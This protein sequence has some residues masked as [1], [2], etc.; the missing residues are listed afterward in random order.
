MGGLAYIVFADE[1]KGPVAKKLDAERIEKLHKIAGD[2]ASLF[3]VCDNV[4]LAAKAAGRLRRTATMRRLP[5][6]N[7]T[8][9]SR[10]YSSLSA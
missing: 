10:E 1:P 6:Q 7:T 4:D 9:S 8:R 3:F 2:N 5:S